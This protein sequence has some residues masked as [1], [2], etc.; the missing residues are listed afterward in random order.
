MKPFATLPWS[1]LL[2]ISVSAR[3]SIP[4]SFISWPTVSAGRGWAATGKEK[5]RP[6]HLNRIAAEDA[7]HQLARCFAVTGK[8]GNHSCSP[9]QLRNRGL[10]TAQSSCCPPTNPA[11]KARCHRL[12][13]FLENGGSASPDPGRGEQGFDRFYGYNC[14]ARPDAPRM[15]N[16]PGRAAFTLEGNT[17][18]V[19]DKCAPNSSLT[20]SRMRTRTNPSSLLSDHHSPPRS[21]SSLRA[22]TS[23]MRRPTPE[24]TNRTRLTFLRRHDAWTSK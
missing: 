9:F 17:A 3:S 13:A 24:A 18:A 2:F 4:T 21:P 22:P 16:R 20:R 12:Y 10:G 7:L 6:P 23:T 19:Y 8:H 14:N 5:I 15:T 11:P 1:R